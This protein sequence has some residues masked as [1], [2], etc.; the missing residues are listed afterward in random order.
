MSKRP[1]L[2][3]YQYMKCETHGILTSQVVGVAMHPG[4][5][6]SDEEDR[7]DYAYCPYCFYEYMETTFP[8]RLSDDI[9]L[10]GIGLEF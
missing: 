6:F 7:S 5:S 9:D 3:G 10:E 2:V 1:T 4:D 8:V